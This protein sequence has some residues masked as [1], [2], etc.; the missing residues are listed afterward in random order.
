VTHQVRGV[1]HRLRHSSWTPR[2]ISRRRSRCSNF[3]GLPLPAPGARRTL[4]RPGKI[5]HRV[6]T[7]ITHPTHLR[8]PLAEPPRSAPVRMA[9]RRAPGGAFRLAGADART[10]GCRR[11]RWGGVDRDRLPQESPV[12]SA[13]PGTLPAAGKTAPPV[14]WNKHRNS[15]GSFLHSSGS[16]LPNPRRPAC[17][18]AGADRQR[19]MPGVMGLQP[20]RLHRRRPVAERPCL[21]R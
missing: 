12:G 14:D 21:A 16:F 4:R 11:R 6:R 3:H 15:D 5:P 10:S 9:S 20:G 8:A 13:A 18:L 2:V 19:G 17:A 1:R 7:P